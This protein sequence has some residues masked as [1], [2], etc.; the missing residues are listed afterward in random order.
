MLNEG[1]GQRAGNDIY[2]RDRLRRMARKLGLRLVK[3]WRTQNNGESGLSAAAR[4]PGSGTSE[5]PNS[6]PVNPLADLDKCG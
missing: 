5:N 3:G 1:N 4:Q 6:V 2:E